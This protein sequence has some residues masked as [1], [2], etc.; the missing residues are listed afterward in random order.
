[1]TKSQRESLRLFY[2]SI[3]T[4]EE[5]DL[6][7]TV[8]A[9]TDTDARK[10]ILDGF[11]KQVEIPEEIR[12]LILTS[13][14]TKEDR[15]MIFSGVVRQWIFKLISLIGLSIAFLLPCILNAATIEVTWAA[16]TEPDLMGYKVYVNDDSPVD[17][18]NVT[19]YTYTASPQYGEVHSVRVTAYNTSD[20]ESD[21]SESCDVF[22]PTTN[23]PGMPGQITIIVRP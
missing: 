13:V 18:G 9:S 12:F 2:Q 7:Y 19:T 16:N 22:V 15:I 14:L 20:M 8:M 10:K 6:F 3:P 23:K 4:Q 11:A 17:V 1:M 21:K 5:K